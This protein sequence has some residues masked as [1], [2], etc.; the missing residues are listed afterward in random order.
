MEKILKPYTIIPPHLYIKRSA[1]RQLSD[2][3]SDMGRPGYVLVSRQMGKTNLL[4]NAKRELGNEND[5]FIYVDLSN[6]FDS[7]QSCFQNIIDLAI[8]TNEDTYFEAAKVILENRKNLNN[9]PPHKQ[10]SN[11]LRILLKHTNGKLIII[12]DEIDAL[13]NTNYSDKIFAQIRSVYFSRVNFPELERLTY[14]L[15][16]V[17]EPT[18]IIKDPKISPFNIGEKIFLNDFSKDEFLTFIEKA[19][20]NTLSEEIIEQVFYWTNGNPRMTWDLCAEIENNKSIITSKLNV[21]DIVKKLY[22]TSFDKPPIDNIREMVIADKKIRDAIIE[23]DYNKGSEVADNVKS[24]L[25]LAGIINY[26]ENNIKIKNRII[27]NALSSNWLNSIKEQEKGLLK[28]ASE[29]FEQ[30][31]YTEAIETYEKFIANND[32]PDKETENFAYYYLGFAFYKNF[33]FEKAIE[34]LLKSN[35]ALNE[36]PKFVYR[37]KQII[38]LC[39]YYDAKYE[40]SIEYFK[41]IIDNSSKDELYGRALLNYGAASINS[42]NDELKIEAIEIFKKLTFEDSFDKNLITEREIDELKSI[43]NYNLGLLL[44]DKLENNESKYYLKKALETKKIELK[45]IL[46]LTLIKSSSDDYEN[47]ILLNSLIEC[48]IENNI[49]LIEKD[50]EKPLDLN[51]EN[52][53]EILTLAFK[54]NIGSFEKLLDYTTKNIFKKEDEIKVIY[55][56]AMTSLNTDNSSSG[57]EILKYNFK[58]HYHDIIKNNNVY[59]YS[60]LKLLSYFVKAKEEIKYSLEYLGCFKTKRL[61]PIDLYDFDIVAHTIFELTTKK[62]YEQANNLIILFNT[63][64]NEVNEDLLVNYI[65][66]QHMHLQIQINLGNS[67]GATVIAAAIL[68]DINNKKYKKEKSNLLAEKEIQNIK[69]NAINFLKPR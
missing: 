15:S 38:G 7:E 64:K 67:L 3:I 55:D 58:V 51:I 39:Y 61:E 60:N 45:P 56:I 8:E 21:D 66:L 5:K 6:I 49:L 35:F 48:I 59:G 44:K 43:S 52:L 19:K 14:I 20:L 28:I 47:S 13:T 17:V 57:I 53:Q 63:L 42:K 62:Q 50:P 37:I 9:I 30:Q 54:V 24:K 23:I 31:K 22:L 16:G 27:K 69:N 2:I 34:I 11:E 18:E 29:L 68:N 65:L 41:Y 4:L 1:D 40:S 32:F 10:H 12:L 36:F 33:Q 25:Y 26:E 46:Y